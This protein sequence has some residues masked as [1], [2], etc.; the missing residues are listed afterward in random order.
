MLFGVQRRI[1]AILIISD[2]TQREQQLRALAAKVG[3]SVA[4]TYTT[5]GKHLEEE[6]IRRIQ[7]AAR[8][9]RDSRLWWFAVVSRVA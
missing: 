1:R 4:S 3:C 2:L 9:E 7:E 5:Y 8:E 6:L